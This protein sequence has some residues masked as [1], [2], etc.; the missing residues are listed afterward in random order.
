M[1]IKFFF[2]TVTK[3][4]QEYI[5]PEQNDE[6]K[7]LGSEEED[8]VLPLDPEI[9]TDNL[10]FPIVVVCTKV[11]LNTRNAGSVVLH[12]LSAY[13]ALYSVVFHV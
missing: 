4:F 12:K 3:Q 1:V 9:L 11:C 10:G 8:V 2:H 13:L 6:K 5:D 7:K